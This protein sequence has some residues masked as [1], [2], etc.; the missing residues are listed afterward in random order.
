MTEIDRRA[1]LGALVSGAAVATMG[2]V[3]MPDTAESTPFSIGAGRPATPE[4]PVE[5][6]VWV[7]R[8]RVRRCW[9]RHGRRVCRWVWI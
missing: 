6:A 1:M 8:R 9:W 4:N 3:L 5:K 2:L 7:H